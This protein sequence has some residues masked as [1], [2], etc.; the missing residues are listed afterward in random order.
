MLRLAFSAVLVFAMSA[1]AD[2][3]MTVRAFFTAYAGGDE[4]AARE[5]WEGGALPA[6]AALTMRVR[7]MRLDA[8]D[9]Q[10]RELGEDDAVAEVE[11]TITASSAVSAGKSWQE[12]D[13]HELR[14]RRT[15]EGWKIAGWSHPEETLLDRYEKGAPGERAAVL[16]SLPRTPTMAARLAARSLAL[17]NRSEHVEASGL[18]SLGVEIAFETGDLRAIAMALSAQSHLFRQPPDIKYEPAAEAAT[19]SIL[20]GEAAGDP[21]AIAHGNLRLGR[22]QQYLSEEDCQILA[23]VTALADHLTDLSIVSHAEVLIAYYCSF[24]GMTREAIEHALRALRYG[25]RSGD[26]AAIVAGRVALVGAYRKQNDNEL[27]ALHARKALDIAR[28]HGFSGPEAQMLKELGLSA[29]NSRQYDAAAKLFDESLAIY[30]EKVCDRINAAMVQLY[31]AQLRSETGDDA[32]AVRDLHD[33]MRARETLPPDLLPFHEGLRLHARLLL[34]WGRAED[35][36]PILN[37]YPHVINAQVMTASA[38]MTLGRPAEARA[39][40]E[41]FMVRS[42]PWRKEIFGTERQHRFFTE[43]MSDIYA[44]LVEILVASGDA[45]E[46]FRVAQRVKARVLREVIA[47][48]APG[49]EKSADPEEK[50]LTESVARLN[51][52]LVAE[53]DPKRLRDIREELSRTRLALEDVASRSKSGAHL[54]PAEQ[55]PA[56]VDIANVVERAVVLD[57]IVSPRQTTVF[58]VKRGGDGKPAITARVIART[59]TELAEEVDALRAALEQRNLQYGA[60]S[61]SL[62]RRLVGPVEQDI[63]GAGLICIAPAGVLWKVPFHALRDPKGRYLAERSGLIYTPSVAVLAESMR[64]DPAPGERRPTLLALANPHINAATVA[65]VRSYNE[66]AQ[67]GAIPEAEEEV[68]ELARLYGPQ[69]SK[70]YIGDQ[71]RE[72]VLKREAGTMDILHVASHGLMDHHAPMFSAL[73]LS[74]TADEKNEDGLLEA[75]EISALRR[76]TRI[77]VLSACETGGGGVSSVD[78]VIGLSWAFMAAGCPTAVVSQ[79]KAVSAPTAMLMVELHRGL[80]SGAGTA[81]ALQKAQ[82]AVMRDPRFAHPYYWAPFVVVGAP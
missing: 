20:F 65:Q 39:A 1:Q 22:A 72:S 5:L 30:S 56:A 47:Q 69:R 37:Y 7:C 44:A 79:W 19:Q 74:K 2:P 3:R 68:R 52:A 13:R 81:T 75:R 76:G 24:Y 48:G 60:L 55:D 45:E 40:L 12:R 80:V 41:A 54:I 4:S 58:V 51:A 32:A 21:D 62:Y 35:A 38:L 10:L 59:E 34:R 67:L 29:M 6:R 77:A 63:A 71:A 49:G 14:L 42:E 15:A 82:L 16:R 28:E 53:R 70:V 36:L 66:R 33:V 23:R 43:E 64:R 31:R 11:T 57:Y 25:E 17:K 78:G 61:A 9:V 73:V 26:A 46:A 27:A 8:M 50:R 18:A